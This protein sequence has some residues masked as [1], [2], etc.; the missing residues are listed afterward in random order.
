MPKTVVP[1][2][3]WAIPNFGISKVLMPS[4]IIFN[5]YLFKISQQFT[6]RK[7]KR[8]IAWSLNKPHTFG[9]TGLVVRESG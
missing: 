8:P 1:N 3:F 4:L 2:Q 5:S 7:L 9:I 6:R